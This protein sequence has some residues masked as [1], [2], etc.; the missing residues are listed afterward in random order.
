MDDF[1]GYLAA[2]LVFAAFSMKSMIRLRITGILSNIAFLAYG[3]RGDLYPVAV[4]HA[5]L[6]PLNMIHL[7]QLMGITEIIKRLWA[8]RTIIQRIGHTKELSV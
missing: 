7:V 4:L 8:W 2:V 1:T 3:L 6:L 5:L